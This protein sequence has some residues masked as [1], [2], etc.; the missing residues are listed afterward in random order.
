MSDQILASPAFPTMVYTAEKPEFLPSVRTVALEKL[1]G[2]EFQSPLY[3][4]RMSDPME[5]DERIQDF[6]RFTATTSLDILIDQGYNMEGLN[7]YFESMWCQE[8]HK[9]SSMEQHTHP[10]VLIVG[11]YFIDVPDNSPVVS[12]FDPRPGKVACPLQETQGSDPR[13]SSNAITIFPRPG[14]LVFTNSWLPHAVSRNGSDSPFRFIH[15]N[16]AVTPAPAT[17]AVEVV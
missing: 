8:H 16:V 12:L 3:P 15:F 13:L 11:F 6:A 2:K 1:A 17:D 10:Q 9:T 14:L 5:M 7:A 4:F